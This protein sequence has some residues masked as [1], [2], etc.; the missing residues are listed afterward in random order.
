MAKK[1]T[2]KRKA[3]RDPERDE[4]NRKILIASTAIVM[5]S[6]IGV[7]SALGIQQLDQLAE[8]YV[9]PSSIPLIIHWPT[10]GQDA[11]WMP[12]NEQQQITLLLERAIEGAPAIS[13]IPLK[14]A[15]LALKD[16]AW[17]NGN[18]EVKWNANGETEVF[19]QWRV[20][21]AAVRV[22]QRE[23]VVDWDR[24]V[25]PLDYGIGESLQFYFVNP[26]ARL[27]KT[28][29]TWEGIDLKDGLKVLEMLQI[30]GLLDQIEG[31]DLG[32]RQQAGT[33]TLLTTRGSKIYWGAGPGRERPA[34]EVAPRK[35][36]RMIE[37]REHT[38]FVDGRYEFVDLT[39]PEIFVEEQLSD[40]P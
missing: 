21:A 16:P 38:G 35:I 40:D 14:E 28:G 29:E 37:L 36:R 34:E 18:P 20:P 4:R 12:Y 31:V 5:T 27:P 10:N 7:G 24:Q 3:K 2:T 25:L 19:A 9:A 32:S 30:N 22:G 17:I 8:Q 1:K 13:S 11:T 23:V 33:L 26:D 15:G 6:A 39:G